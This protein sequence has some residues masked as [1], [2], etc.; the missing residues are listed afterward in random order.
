LDQG[1][2]SYHGRDVSLTKRAS[3]GLTFK[4]NYTWSKI[5]DLNSAI[6]APSA[7]NEPSAL[8][9]PYFRR[10]LHRGVG[11][12]S[13]THQFNGYTSYQLP[14]GNGRRSERAPMGVG[15]RLLGTGHGTPA[16]GLQ[17]VSPSH[18]SLAPILP[19]LAIPVIP[20]YRTGIRISKGR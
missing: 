2:S 18:R 1:T 13:L 15:A 11:S 14:F 5:M 20:T 7:G 19:E 3:R 16:V 10:Q 9:S 4:A 17:A 12:Y 6:L 8:S